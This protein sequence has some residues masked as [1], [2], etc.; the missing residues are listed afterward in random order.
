[1]ENVE[2][3]AA[4]L[5]SYGPYAV[6]AL[7]ALVIA[8]YLTKQCYRIK[9]KG[10]NKILSGSIACGAWLVVV[11]MVAY[12]TIAWA[13]DKV[14]IGKIGKLDPAMNVFSD[15]PT[16][17]ELFI[18]NDGDR[19]GKNAWGYALISSKNI[20]NKNNCAAFTVSWTVGKTEHSVDF[21]VPVSVLMTGQNIKVSFKSHGPNQNT[22]GDVFIYRDG[23]WSTKGR[24]EKEIVEA[25]PGFFRTAY[26]ADQ[27]TLNK[28]SSGLQSSNSA[29]RSQ[30]RKKMRR[31]SKSELKQ[32]KGMLPPG[33]SAQNVVNKE[34]A[35]R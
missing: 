1:M 14:Y 31:L 21:E 15:P 11:A 6:L 5:I 27:A 28:I 24:C 34:L 26:A 33:S 22:E 19:G 8:P 13:P 29:T 10:F 32:L 12:I 23:N 16:G 20:E 9:G 4:L 35:R 3:G 17:T 2:S 18:K 7:F 25:S 30:A